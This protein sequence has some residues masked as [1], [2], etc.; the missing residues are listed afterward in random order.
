MTNSRNKLFV[1]LNTNDVS[2]IVNGLPEEFRSEA[3]SLLT[4]SQGVKT[5]RFWVR[6]DPK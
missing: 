5:P 3:L 2:N 1:T 6:L 4:R